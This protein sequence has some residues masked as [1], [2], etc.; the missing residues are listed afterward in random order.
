MNKFAGD[1]KEDFK[2]WLADYCEATGDCEWTE[3]IPKYS[4]DIQRNCICIWW[5][6]PLTVHGTWM[7]KMGKFSQAGNMSVPATPRYNMIMT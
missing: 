2:V 1:G 6:Y 4:L 3:K 7:D 5:P